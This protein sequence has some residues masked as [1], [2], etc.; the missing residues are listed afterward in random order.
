[1][2]KGLLVAM[3]LT[4]TVLLAGWGKK[5]VE[6]LNKAKLIDLGLAIVPAAYGQEGNTANEEGEKNGEDSS[7]VSDEDKNQTQQPDKL[8]QK[9]ANH[10]I[11]VRDERI[12]YNGKVC[13]DVA[14]LKSVLVR[15][16]K[17]KDYVY[18]IDDFAEAHVYRQILDML[19][20]LASS[21][22]L[23]YGCD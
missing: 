2:K 7:Q 19:E 6:L 5:S 9:D 15:N 3:L 14:A 1:M 22:Q 20:G 17:A 8:G 4:S 12:L 18:V 16:Y 10:T 11:A 21:M 13:K 23:M